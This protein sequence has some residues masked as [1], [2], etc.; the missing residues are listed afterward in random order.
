MFVNYDFICE[1]N[2]LIPVW[3]EVIIW[4]NAG[5]LSIGQLRTNMNK[6]AIIFWQ[7]NEFE[8]IRRMTVILS[9]P[10]CVKSHERNLL[11][12]AVMKMYLYF[13]L[14]VESHWTICKL[15][16]TLSWLEVSGQIKKKNQN[17]VWKVLMQKKSNN[18]ID[19]LLSWKVKSKFSFVQTHW[20]DLCIHYVLT[21]YGSVTLYCD[22]DQDEHWLS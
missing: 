1:D 7:E 3:H 20:S 2:G 14:Q 22:R 18:I 17:S 9:W 19:Y 6:N 11:L 10:K 5:L 15:S 13:C 12:C 8:S 16:P 21:L 4:N